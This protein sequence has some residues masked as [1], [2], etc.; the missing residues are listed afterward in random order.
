[1]KPEMSYIQKGK[2]VHFKTYTECEGV[3]PGS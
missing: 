3:E 1:M 2:A